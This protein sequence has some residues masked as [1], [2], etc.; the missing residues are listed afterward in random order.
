[1][2]ASRRIGKHFKNII[3]RPR[4]VV[5][6]AR[7][8][9]AP[10]RSSAIWLPPRA[11]CSA[12]TASVSIRSSGIRGKVFGNEHDFRD[13]VNDFAGGCD[14]RTNSLRQERNWRS[15]AQV[16]R[17]RRS[18]PNFRS[19]WTALPR[20][21]SRAASPRSA[22]ASRSRRVDAGRDPHG[23]TL[24][25]VSKSHAA[26]AIEAAIGAGERV[27]G[28]NRVQEAKAKWPVLKAS[29]PGPRACISSDPLQTNKVREAVELFDV[30]ETLDRPKLARALAD[31]M[32]RDRPPPAPLHRGEYRRGTAEGRR[33]AWRCRCFHRL[34]PARLWARDRWA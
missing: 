8:S 9:P 31:E 34:L 20:R 29:L 12:R 11:R 22:T 26:A 21:R 2:D 6:G 33:L 17:S 23:V 19:R 14:R 24:V 4:I 3:F 15:G 13:P 27:F 30:I 18:G 16:C 10:P 7:R 1:M 5:R 25:C 32:A 28:E